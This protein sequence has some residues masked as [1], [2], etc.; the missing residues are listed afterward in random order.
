MLRPA[1]VTSAAPVARLS[2][3]LSAG[4]WQVSVQDY[5]RFVHWGYGGEGMIGRAPQNWPEQA[6]GGGAS[7]G[8]GMVQR[9]FRG[10]TNFWHFG[11]LCFPQRVEAGSYVVQ[12]EQDWLAV[13]AFDRCLDWDAMFELDHILTRGVFPR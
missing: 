13:V 10:S 2:V 1:G 11:Q 12:W 8:V 6:M 7:Y 5:A 4:G 9:A 3:L